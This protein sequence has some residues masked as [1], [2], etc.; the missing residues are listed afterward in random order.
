M[1]KIMKRVLYGIAG[2]L[3]LAQFIRPGKNQSNDDTQHLRTMMPVPA[4]VEDIL[5]TACNDCHSNYTVYPWY[6]DIQPIGWWLAHHV[7]E[8]KQHLNFSV[9]ATYQPKRQAHK[10]EEIAEVIQ[11][12]EMPMTSYTWMHPTAKL[13]E[14]QKQT[15]INWANAAAGKGAESEE[16]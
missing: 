16:E 11:K 1:K 4:D 12:D 2:F 13:S 3:V 6:A 10:L 5:K 9:F 8:G 15:L 14:A 7:D